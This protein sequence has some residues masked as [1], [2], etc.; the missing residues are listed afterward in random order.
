[1]GTRAGGAVW[2]FAATVPSKRLIGIASKKGAEAS[3]RFLLKDTGVRVLQRAP[4]WARTD[5]MN[6]REAEQA[7]PL[8]KFITETMSVFATDAD[9]ILVEAAKAFR[10]NPGPNE[11]ALVNGF[12]QQAM[13]LFGAA[14]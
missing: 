12:N 10:S 11:H 4:P 7:M 13:A 5:L 3:Q 1:V 2:K 6:S 14:G 8:D 9:E